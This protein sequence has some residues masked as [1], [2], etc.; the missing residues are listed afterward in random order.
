[1]IQ[2]VMEPNRGWV[3]SS[4]VT[5]R[6]RVFG[7]RPSRRSLG[8]MFLPRPVKSVRKRP[9]ESMQSDLTVSVV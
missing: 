2:W 6:V 3:R 8:E 1:M 4:S 7:S 9:S 5:A